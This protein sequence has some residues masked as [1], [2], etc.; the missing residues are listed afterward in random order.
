MGLITMSSEFITHKI[1]F[2]PTQY[3]YLIGAAQVTSLLVVVSSPEYIVILNF[4]DHLSDSR[5][6][7]ISS[8][9]GSFRPESAN[10]RKTSILLVVQTARCYFICPLMRSPD[11][12]MGSKPHGKRE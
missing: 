3:D 10:Y 2:S 7:H 11:C 8:F 12:L 9:A 6:Y 5:E 1:I 4:G